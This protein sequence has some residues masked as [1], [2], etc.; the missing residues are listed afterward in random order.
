MNY[1][2]HT[3][4]RYRATSILGRVHAAF[5]NSHQIDTMIYMLDEIVLA[6]LMTVMDLEFKKAMHCHNKGYKSEYDYG[7]PSQ[8]MRPVHIY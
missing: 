8:V 6:R 7:L 1:W 2:V 3:T 4:E 5:F